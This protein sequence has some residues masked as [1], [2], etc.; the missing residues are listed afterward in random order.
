MTPDAVRI[1][2]PDKLFIGGAWVASMTTGVS[3]LVVTESLVVTAPFT[4]AVIVVQ[5]PVSR[6]SGVGSGAPA[7][8]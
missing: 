2:H 6:G 7:R 8:P 4:C 3:S 5:T 1:A